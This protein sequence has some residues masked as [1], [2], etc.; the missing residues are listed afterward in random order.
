MK[1]NL[2]VLTRCVVSQKR[3][4]IFF[5]SLML[6]LPA[7]ASNDAGH[8]QPAKS[9]LSK[10][11][12]IKKI[13]D[14][15]VL[16]DI[17][18]SM[19]KT[20]PDNLRRPAIRLLAGLIPQGSRAGIWNFGKQVNM[21]VK[22]G[23]VNDA[24]RELA[25]QQS[26]KIN[27]A[28]L[29]TNIEGAMRNVSFDWKT[30][31]PRYKRNLIILTDGH[32]DISKDEKLNKASR[33]RILKELLPRLEKAQVRIHTI[34]LSD[35][36][37]ESLLSTL[38]AYTD[39]LY[40]KV[41]NANELQKLFLQ[42]LEQSVNLDTIPLKDNRFNVDASINDMTLLVFNNDKA[43][44][45]TIVMPAKRTWSEKTHTE[46]VKWFSDDGF[47]LITIKKPQQG[48]WKIMAPT[49]E[50]NRVVVATNLKLKLNELPGYLMLG[51]ILKIN[52][53]LEEDEKPLTDQRLLSKFKFLLK[54]NTE[55]SAAR[56]YP[57]EKSKEDE[58]SYV[59]QLAPIF[60]EGNHEL[61]IQ[62]KSPTVQREVRHQIK[63]Y[64]TPA[65]IK[66][67]EDHG[68]YQIKVTPYANLLR[69]SSIKIHV[70]LNDKSKHELMRHN[71]SW[72]VDVDK[73]FHETMF[74]L[75]VDATRADG[76]AISMSFN[77]VLS[78]K[79]ASHKL[80]L[81]VEKETPHKKEL[82]DKKEKNAHPKKKESAHKKEETIKE[83]VKKESKINWTLII[84]S[85]VIGNVLL[86]GSFVGGYIFIKRRKEKL[87]KALSGE[88][89]N[90]NI[91]E[92]EVKEEKP[93]E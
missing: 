59:V 19:K 15:R 58:Y 28:G 84:T 46:Q 75:N 91:S 42:M 45:T 69:P 65:E 27:S 54:R 10:K 49:D 11:T 26:K 81:Y 25:R 29:F 60:K 21:A 77:K 31:D 37:D 66:V 5:L 38:S 87:A 76:K 48:Q 61:V 4:V 2:T 92:E 67:S 85:I 41:K 6:V 74:T 80:K 79:E 14:L 8:E 44:P 12:R 23:S 90:D 78:E 68:K 39:G 83:E 72:T 89:D 64:A 34:A 9:A 43:H 52:T 3:T 1:S 30:P 35:D 56:E 16:V 93:K 24:W 18:G 17:S 53:Y 71:N 57:L 63:V 40:K 7:H 73:Q 20:D 22:V 82:M 13:T 47:D 50:N 86:I 36:V 51:D 88:M 55:G 70:I 62:A 32:V 33:K